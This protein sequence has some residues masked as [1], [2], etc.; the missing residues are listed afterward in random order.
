MIFL[1]VKHVS[2]VK[3]KISQS[4]LGCVK[5]SECG[6]EL[7]EEFPVGGSTRSLKV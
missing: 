3:K 4:A 5:Y 2:V 1:H 6:G 7:P